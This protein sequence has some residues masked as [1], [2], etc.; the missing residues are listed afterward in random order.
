MIGVANAHFCG[1]EKRESKEIMEICIMEICKVEE[2]VL[3][4]F[5]LEFC[6]KYFYQLYVKYTGSLC[7]TVNFTHD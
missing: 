7:L 6:K 1:K 5:L 2:Y 3:S 4:D